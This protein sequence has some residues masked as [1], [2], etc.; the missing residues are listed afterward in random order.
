MHVSLYATYLQCS[1]GCWILWNWSYRWLLATM[2]MLEV[3]PGLL[4][5]VSALSHWVIYPASLIL[6]IHMCVYMYVCACV[7]D[8]W[9]HAI[10][11]Q[12]LWRPLEAAV[13]TAAL[14]V[15][16]QI[17]WDLEVSS[18]ETIMLYTKKKMFKY[19]TD[20]LW[21]ITLVIYF[22][23]QMTVDTGWFWLSGICSFLSYCWWTDGNTS[24]SLPVGFWSPCSRS[25]H[26]IQSSIGTFPP[27]GCKDEFRI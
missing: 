23:I 20:I 6:F 12:C 3:N 11:L 4:R 8:V 24:L 14:G 13:H 7:V 1:Q 25:T 18:P 9:M 16:W 10:Y 2:W 19:I 5:V 21:T 22:E 27:S 15:L 17:C 26:T